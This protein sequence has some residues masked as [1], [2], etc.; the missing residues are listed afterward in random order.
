MIV[1]MNEHSY[2]NSEIFPYEMRA[3]GLARLVGMPTPG[4]VIWTSDFK[5]LDGTGARL[6]QAGAYRLDGTCMEN[7]GERPDVTVRLSPEDWV[8]DRDPQ[9]DKAIELLTEELGPRKN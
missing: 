2:S 9:L 3:R 4:Y 6:P 5:L 7:L 1:L 8:A